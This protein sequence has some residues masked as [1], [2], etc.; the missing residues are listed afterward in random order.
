MRE[1]ITFLP[2]VQDCP[3]GAA[4]CDPVV[5]MEPSWGEGAGLRG[6]GQFL[7]I[8]GVGGGV[9]LPARL[10]P[11]LLILTFSGGRGRGKRRQD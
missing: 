8:C 4:G 11:L 5:G 6:E 9:G 3:L 2:V 7:I 1:T 10:H